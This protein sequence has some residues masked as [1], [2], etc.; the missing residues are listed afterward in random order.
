MLVPSLSIVHIQQQTAGWKIPQQNK[1]LNDMQTVDGHFTSPPPLTLYVVP[2]HGL[3]IRLHDHV[4][5]VQLLVLY[6]AIQ[7]TDNAAEHNCLP[8]YAACISWFS[9]IS[10]IVESF[11]V[12]AQNGRNMDAIR[13]LKEDNDEKHFNLYGDRI[14]HTSY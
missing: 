4:E 9:C 5:Q 10:L 12:I 14:N 13:M 11:F 3:H 8:L 7:L 1:H 2:K 6:T